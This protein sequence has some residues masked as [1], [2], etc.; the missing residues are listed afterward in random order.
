[1]NN[2]KQVVNIHRWTGIDYTVQV[3]MV[4]DILNLWKPIN[5]ISEENNIGTVINEML[6]DKY[7]G[8][9]TR[10]SLHNTLKREIIEKLIVAFE[11][12]SITIPE[13]EELFGELSGFSC[14]Y[15]ANTQSV[16]YAA[17]NG[18]HDDMV[19]SLA[20]AYHA[21]NHNSGKYDIR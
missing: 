19:L 2:L 18:L 8:K 15:N 20:Y 17:R 1:M 21:I 6:R 11:T 16:K 14:T 4:I 12:K 9:I 7:K 13:D 5:T 3:K 10:I